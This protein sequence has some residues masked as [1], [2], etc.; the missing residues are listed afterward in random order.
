MT[1]PDSATGERQVVV[2]VRPQEGLRRH[3]VNPSLQAR[4]PQFLDWGGRPSPQ[5]LPAP[6]A[7]DVVEFGTPMQGTFRKEFDYN[8]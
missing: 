5:T 2:A 7:D 1:M 3:A 6:V 8:D 4:R